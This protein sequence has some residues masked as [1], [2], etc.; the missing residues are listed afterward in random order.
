VVIAYA[1]RPLAIWSGHNRQCPTARWIQHPLSAP[2][3][4]AGFYWQKF[5]HYDKHSEKAH[6]KASLIENNLIDVHCKL[7]HSFSRY[8]NTRNPLVYEQKPYKRQFRIEAT[9]YCY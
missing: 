7:L 1:A 9:K 8:K 2:N 6:I 4:Q 3:G 5:A